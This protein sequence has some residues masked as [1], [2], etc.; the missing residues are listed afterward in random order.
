M[1]D[2]I[3]GLVAAP[4]TP[5]NEDGSVNLE[6]IETQAAFLHRNGVAGVFICGTTGEGSS[7]SAHERIEIANRWAE[8]APRELKII[9]HVGHN[10][11][12]TAKALAAHAQE[13]GAWGIG[14]LPPFYFKPSGIEELV[15]FC[16]EVAS[17][18]PEI[19]FFYYHI[20]SM[21]GVD[22]PMRDFLDAAE[23]KIPNL[24]GVKFTRK[25]L[26][27]LGLCLDRFGDRFTML[28][29][30]DEFLLGALALGVRGAVGSTYNFAAP[31]YVKMIEV[32]KKGDLETAR[33]LQFKSMEI[34]DLLASTPQGFMASAKA[35]M[36]M[37]GVDCGPLRPPLP[38]ITPEQ[39]ETLKADLDGIGFFELSGK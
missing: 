38:N 3:E 26:M 22:F 33:A 14:A 6:M 17:A 5:M 7:L 20:P 11:I 30:R 8:T 23:G 1:Q 2:H 10:C 32:F 13:I 18:A 27:D 34:I 36:K 4:F 28:F 39:Y 19:P 29:G 37:L 16:G 15:A 21:T 35:V 31:L 25:D 12:R 24:A 9:V